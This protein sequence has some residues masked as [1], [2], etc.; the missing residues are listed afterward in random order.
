MIKMV[1]YLEVLSGWMAQPHY[2]LLI[3]IMVYFVSAALDF[4]VGSFNAAHT[5]TETFS[6][7]TAQL[8]IVRKLVTLAVMILM[9]PLALMLPMEVGIYSLTVLYLGIAGSEIYSVLG[10]V[11]IVKDGEKHKNMIGT[12]FTGILDNVFKSKGVDK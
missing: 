2:V 11:G 3:L 12:L 8:G 6:T 10:H 5:P 1:N 9:V 7:K 4:M